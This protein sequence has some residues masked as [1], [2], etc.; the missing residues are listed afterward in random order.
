MRPRGNATPTCEDRAINYSAP[1]AISHLPRENF[2]TWEFPVLHVRGG[3]STGLIIWD[4]IAPKQL[5]LR[6]E[7]LRHL[8]GLPFAGLNL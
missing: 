3:T 6:E 7:L 1:I 8:M 4:R 2:G 5:E